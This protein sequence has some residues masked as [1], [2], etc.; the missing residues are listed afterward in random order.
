MRKYA[1]DDFWFEITH[2]P[3]PGDGGT[4]RYY[5]VTC[6]K[7]RRQSKYHATDLSND[8]LRKVFIRQGWML[9]KTRN[10]HLCPDCSKRHAPQPKVEPAVV[11]EIP[12]PQVSAP[13]Q[14]SRLESLWDQSSEDERVEFWNL[15]RR[16]Y[17]EGKEAAAR[18]ALYDEVRRDRDIASAAPPPSVE[19]SIGPAPSIVE[20]EPIGTADNDDD[21]VA[22]WWKELNARDTK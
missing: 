1:A 20:N 7:C 13:P 16:R 15:L 3:S 17:A 12:S 14:V 6:R 21:D 5:I 10:R 22:D 2:G 19:T 4:V 8:A 11:I 9:G 18:D